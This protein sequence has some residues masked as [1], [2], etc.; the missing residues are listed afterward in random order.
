MS[1]DLEKYF[2]TTSCEEV[3]YIVCPQSS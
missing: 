1:K 2:S 3:H